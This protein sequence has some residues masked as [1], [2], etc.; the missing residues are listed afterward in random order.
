MYV[1][2]KDIIYKCYWAESDTLCFPAGWHWCVIMIYSLCQWQSRPDQTP[3]NTEYTFAWNQKGP[4]NVFRIGWYVC[5][6]T[7]MKDYIR[8]NEMD[9]PAIWWI[10]HGVGEDDEG[11]EADRPP[12]QE[13]P[14]RPPSPSSVLNQYDKMAS[15]PLVST[16]YVRLGW[17]GPMSSSHK[18]CFS[19]LFKSILK[20]LEIPSNRRK[21]VV[22]NGDSDYTLYTFSFKL[23]DLCIKYWPKG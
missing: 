7:K 3:Q 16:L 1:I 8:R 9:V 19:L 14:T 22:F 6:R 21:S 2:M 23:K 20:A 15:W 18:V 10:Q 12:P 13:R 11:D 4:N 5:G 17:N